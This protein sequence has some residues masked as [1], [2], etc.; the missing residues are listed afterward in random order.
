[1]TKM[2]YVGIG[3][4]NRAFAEFKPM[5][6]KLEQMKRHCRPF[7][8]DYHALCIAL[9]ALTTTVFHFTRN[10]NFFNEESGNHR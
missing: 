6:K 7:G 2:N 4:P 9:E 5:F 8:R 10:P 1:M 3:D